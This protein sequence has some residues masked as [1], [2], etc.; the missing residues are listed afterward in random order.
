VC[1]NVLPELSSYRLRPRL[2]LF[3]GGAQ[4]LIFSRY[5]L[6]RIAREHHDGLS[7]QTSVDREPLGK[8][9]SGLATT[10]CDIAARRNHGTFLI[11]LEPFLLS[12]LGGS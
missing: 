6:G 9:S 1:V 10:Q 3:C 11:S 12:F 2:R 4:L 7:E 5:H 8:L